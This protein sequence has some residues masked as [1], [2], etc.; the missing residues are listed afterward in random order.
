MKGKRP[1]KMC[2]HCVVRR[3]SQKL[4]FIFSLRR[5]QYYSLKPAPENNTYRCR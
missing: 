1:I 4:F 3:V 2:F 5:E